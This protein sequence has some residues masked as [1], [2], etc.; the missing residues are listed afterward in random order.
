MSSTKTT[1]FMVNCQ[2]TGWIF[3][4]TW[5]VRVTVEQAKGKTSNQIVRDHFE[6]EDTAKK[7]VVKDMALNP[8]FVQCYITSFQDVA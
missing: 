3:A 8:S 7:L 5:P 4:R 1:V 6:V 2:K